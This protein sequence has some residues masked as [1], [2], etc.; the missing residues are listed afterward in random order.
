MGFF[1]SSNKLAADSLYEREV[2]KY[3]AEKD[4]KIHVI[5]ITSFSKFINQVFGVETQYTNQIDLILS[6][7]QDDGYEI[8]DITHTTVQGQGV[9]GSKEG[10]HSLIRYK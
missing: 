9:F 2:Q 6:R 7:M 3:L 1:D 8:L 10:F 5:M 4:G